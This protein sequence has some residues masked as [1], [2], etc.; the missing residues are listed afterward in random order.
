MLVA[1]NDSLENFIA[2]R[3]YLPEKIPLLKRVAALP[4]AEICRKGEGIYI[5]DSHVAEALPVDSEGRI[6]PAWDGCF[7]L[8]GSQVF[9]LNE[10]ENSLDGRYFGVT[11]LDDVIGVAVPVWVSGNGR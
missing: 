10:P 4:G 7:L 11:N 9:L 1:L 3:N 8:S 5:D 2:Q 6:L